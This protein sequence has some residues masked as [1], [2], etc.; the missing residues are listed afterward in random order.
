MGIQYG[1]T[2]RLFFTSDIPYVINTRSSL[3]EHGRKERR[4]TF[5]RGIGDLRLGLGYWLVAPGR[6]KHALAAGFSLKLPTGNYQAL[7]IF[8]VVKTGLIRGPE[9]ATNLGYSTIYK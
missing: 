2:E 5:S 3:Y 6:K 1:L 4:T 9:D 8:G 7:D